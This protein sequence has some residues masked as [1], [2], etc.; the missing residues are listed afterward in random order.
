MPPSTS[1]PGVTAAG[2][3]AAL[4]K[5]EHPH[6]RGPPPRPRC[7]LATTRVTRAVAATRDTRGR[8]ALAAVS[9]SRHGGRHNRTTM[10]GGGR[11]TGSTGG[12]SGAPG[13]VVACPAP[14]RPPLPC[15]LRGSGR[16]Y[17]RP[18]R[19]PRSRRHSLR[20]ATHH[21]HYTARTSRSTGLP[22]LALR[23]HY[24]PHLPCSHAT[25]IWNLPHV[26]LNSLNILRHTYHAAML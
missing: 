4:E 24:L 17:T 26:S 15:T 20:R 8:G 6:C 14:A 2:Q 10:P 7:S 3:G 12:Q 13:S 1:L 21:L 18:V 22:R 16:H 19:H 11:H 25:G 23:P 9:L 5:L